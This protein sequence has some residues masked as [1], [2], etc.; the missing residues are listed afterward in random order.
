MS[1][2]Y[3]ICENCPYLKENYLETYSGRV[4]KEYRCLKGA[5]PDYCEVKSND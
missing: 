2:E 3:E 1:D 4:I 5:E